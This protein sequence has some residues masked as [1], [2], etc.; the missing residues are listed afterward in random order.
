MGHLASS[1]NQMTMNLQSA[2][3]EIQE[4][5]RNLEHKVEERTRELKATSRSS[6]IRRSLP[7]WERWRRPWRTRSTTR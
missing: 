2:H 6:F 1:F 3:K 7:P 5:I 4:G